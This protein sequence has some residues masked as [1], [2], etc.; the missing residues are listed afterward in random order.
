MAID[1]RRPLV[2]HLVYRFDTGGLENGIVNLI[3]HLP[4]D[5]YRHAVVA[6][7]HVAPAFAQ[8]VRRSGV[9]F[10]SLNKPPGQGMRVFPA[11]YRLL[12]RWRP[13]IV[14]SRNLAPLECQVVAWVAGV[15]VRIHGEHGRDIDDPHGTSRRH[16]W[17]RRVYGCFVQHWV[18]LS[19]ELADYLAGPVG[20][21]RGRIDVVCNGVDTTRFVPAAAARGRAAAAAATHGF[22][23][24]STFV[25][26][27]VGRMEAIK[28][29]P[30]LVNAFVR[31]LQQA[32]ELRGRLRLALVGRGP[33]LEECRQLLQAADVMSLAWL[34]GERA[35]VP[36]VMQGFDAFVLPSLGEG[37]SNTI[38][39]A[40]ASGL[41]VLATAVGGNAELVQ[42]GRTGWLVPAGDVEALAQGIVR[43][44]S[45]P[46]E[47]ERMGYAGRQRV[48][49]QFSLAAMV[50]AY[51]RLYDGL[52]ARR[53][54]T[55]NAAEQ[56]I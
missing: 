31:A 55:P 10:E 45:D 44:A 47:A 4:D 32:P 46:A 26:G 27:T 15:P 16:Q 51:Q 11:L 40:M 56:G 2:V 18:A 36:E 9:V 23:A 28:A 53:G 7:T 35:D 24:G 5:G 8:R 54:S 19:R 42:A 34:P 12:R 50:Q 14:H 20:V 33:L 3:N 13:A 17:M 22:D 48:E 30:L 38:L 1:T 39:E 52:L 29:Q 37:I 41:P 43:L 21:P 6:M 25:V 49:Q